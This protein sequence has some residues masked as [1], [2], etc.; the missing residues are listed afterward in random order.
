MLPVA[1]NV[2]L[3]I[4]AAATAAAEM[5]VAVGYRPLRPVTSFAAANSGLAGN[6]AIAVVTAGAIW[7]FYN[8]GFAVVFSFGPSMLVERGWSVSAAGSATS[9]VLL[10]AGRS[11]PLGGL[12]S[13]RYGMVGAHGLLHCP[14]R[15]R[16]GFS[17]GQQ[18][19]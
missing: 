5:L 15:M 6:T 3:G 13:E 2:P 16:S 7:A 4:V 11:V 12:L 9:I 17:R 10:L 1:T 14:A 8:V 19:N 18:L